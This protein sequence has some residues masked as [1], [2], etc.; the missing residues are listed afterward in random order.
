MSAVAAGLMAG[1]LL[2]IWTGMF[3]AHV[4]ASRI[5]NWAVGGQRPL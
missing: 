1:V 4:F 2:M 5:A 3:L